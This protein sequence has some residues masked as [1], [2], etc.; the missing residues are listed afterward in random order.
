[1]PHADIKYS[2]DLAFDGP[3]MY[4]AIESTILSHDSG[5]G[6]C[7]CRSYPT[8]Q[9]SHTH[10]LVEV[11]MLTKPHRDKAFTLALRDDLEKAIKAQLAQAC[12]FSL[13]LSYT[14]DIYLTNFHE[15]ANK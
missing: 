12:F 8:D 4:Q 9:A 13:A 1:M 5:A 11:S 10:I 3:A 14:D 15:G 2:A 7:K 6:D